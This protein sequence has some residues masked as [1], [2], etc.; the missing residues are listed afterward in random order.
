M[1]PKST[2]L[3]TLLREH[4]VFPPPAEFTKQALVDLDGYHQMCERADADPEGFWGDLA[5]EL[6]VWQ[7]P[8]RTVLQGGLPGA[9][10][11]ADGALNASETCIDQ[12]VR[13]WRRNKAAIV[14]EGEPGAERVL[15][16]QDLAR[17]VGRFANA[18]RKLGVKKGDRV[19]IY[20]PMVPEAAIAML[21]C[22]RHRRDPFRGLRRLLQRVAARSDQDDGSARS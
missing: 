18:L 4:R 15:T 16:Y 14:W 10:W 8:F 3:D 2:A 9:Q 21:A 19:C 12:H 7:Q 17:E 5:R 13:T 6:V 1:D 11:F 20:M 22:A